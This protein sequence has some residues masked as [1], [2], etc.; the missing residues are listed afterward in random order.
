[1]MLINDP[2]PSSAGS[3]ARPFSPAVRLFRGVPSLYQRHPSFFPC[4]SG[5]LPS[6]A[7]TFGRGRGQLDDCHGFE[8]SFNIRNVRNVAEA[9]SGNLVAALTR[10]D[11]A[12]GRAGGKQSLYMSCHAFQE[13]CRRPLR[14]KG[15]QTIPTETG[16]TAK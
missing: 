11:I 12:H 9:Q 15:E 10:G 14:R 13:A 3:S 5:A 16:G 4:T 2:T 6:L 1:M 8:G 7:L